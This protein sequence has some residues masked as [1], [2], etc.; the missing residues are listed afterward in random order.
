MKDLY[1]GLKLTF[2]KD[3]AVAFAGNVS[4][5]KVSG[6]SQL[7][8]TGNGYMVAL[9]ASPKGAPEFSETCYVSLKIDSSNVVTAV[10][11]IQQ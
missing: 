2:K 1:N 8:N 3:G 10:E 9:Y 4:G 5:A 6:S 11:E 7:V